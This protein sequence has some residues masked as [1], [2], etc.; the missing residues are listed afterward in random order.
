MT[1]FCAA[2]LDTDDPFERDRIQAVVH[3]VATRLQDL[4]TMEE[5]HLQYFLSIELTR[6]NNHR[7]RA[8]GRPHADAR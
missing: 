4:R 8:G 1:P 2:G 6:Q 5:V 7:P 3:D